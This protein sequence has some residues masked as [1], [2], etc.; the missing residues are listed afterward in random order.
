MNNAEQ[1]KH[2]ALL[3]ARTAGDIGFG[4]SN[5]AYKISLRFLRW[6]K[7]L[8]DDGNV[9]AGQIYDELEPLNPARGNGHGRRGKK[10]EDSATVAPKNGEKGEKV[11]EM[12]EEATETDKIN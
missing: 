11:A 1:V 9:I 12:T 5:D 3:V 10:T 8:K 7:E 4:S 6:C 2:D